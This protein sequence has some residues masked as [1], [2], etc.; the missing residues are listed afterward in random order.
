VQQALAQKVWGMRLGASEAALAELRNMTTMRDEGFSSKLSGGVL[1]ASG[2]TAAGMSAAGAAA[3][4][5]LRSNSRESSL[6]SWIQER[7]AASVAAANMQQ[8]VLQHAAAAGDAVGSDACSIPRAGPSF[9]GGPS[10]TSSRWRGLHDGSNSSHDDLGH[11]VQPTNSLDAAANGRML[12]VVW[13]N[14]HRR[15]SN[16]SHSSMQCSDTDVL[17]D[18]GTPQHS[19]ELGNITP[20]AAQQQQQQNGSSAAHAIDITQ[21]WFNTHAPPATAAAHAKSSFGS[22]VHWAGAERA[23]NSM[24]HKFSDSSSKVWM[25]SAAAFMRRFLQFGHSGSGQQRPMQQPQEQVPM[26]VLRLGLRVGVATGTL[27]FGVDVANC[28]VE[29]RAKGKGSSACFALQRR[30]DLVVE[31]PVP[32]VCAAPVAMQVYSTAVE[33]ERLQHICDANPLSAC[34]NFQTDAVSNAFRDCRSGV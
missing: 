5:H 33:M 14:K 31:R 18:T 21:S 4:P 16:G 10:F 26:Q 3:V 28:T 34:A 29:D 24:S 19:Q 12:S 1:N 9:T 22:S 23:S 11:L 20:T 6:N 2:S 32:S 17:R 25:H 8:Q 13:L 15:T 30:S 27:P 7:V